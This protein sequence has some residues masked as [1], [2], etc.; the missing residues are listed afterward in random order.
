MPDFQ[1]SRAGAAGSFEPYAMRPAAPARDRV[2]R[3]SGLRASA[4]GGAREGSRGSAWCLPQI[5]KKAGVRMLG[6]PAGWRSLL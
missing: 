5:G 4:L 2:V 1:D 6:R 3:S